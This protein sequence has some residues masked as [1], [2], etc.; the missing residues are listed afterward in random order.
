MDFR[1]AGLNINF[2][3]TG[4]ISGNTLTVTAGAPGTAIA[5]GET[6]IGSGILP[7]TTITSFGTGTGGT[8]RYTLSNSHTVASEPMSLNGGNDKF[9][10][11]TQF[12][13]VVNGA[14]SANNEYYYIGS[15][16][17]SVP[18]DIFNGGANGQ[19]V[20]IFPDAFKSQIIRSPRRG[21]ALSNLLNKERCMLVR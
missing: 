20:A 15:G 5:L 21:V 11:G 9:F 3:F 19:N 12:N 1:P 4:S 13:D 6:I 17:G 14:G 10:A 16:S 2:N 8:G 7:N 18:S